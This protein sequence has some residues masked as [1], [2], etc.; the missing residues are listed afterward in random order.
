MVDH[1][2]CNAQGS[3]T[4]R[5]VVRG[6]QD[7]KDHLLGR[8][9]GGEKKDCFPKVLGRVTWSSSGSMVTAIDHDES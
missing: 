7:P 3:W 9:G 4:K 8:K 1:C 6:K 2:D 5:W